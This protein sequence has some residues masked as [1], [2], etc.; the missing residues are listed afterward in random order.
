[1]RI[2]RNLLI[3]LLLNFL[4][5]I[6]Y[7]IVT[8]ILPILI[9]EK[10]ASETL[11]G[12]IIATFSLS[13]VLSIPF[14]PYIMTKFRKRSLLIFSLSLEVSLK[15]NFPLGFICFVFWFIKVFKCSFYFL[16]YLFIIKINSGNS[17][18]NNCYY[19]I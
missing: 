12:F 11:A 4:N 7:T 5:G 8:P 19:F 13:N 14:M 18:R 16:F 6:G 1:M 10:G 17:C 3:A 9:K 2:S 15:N